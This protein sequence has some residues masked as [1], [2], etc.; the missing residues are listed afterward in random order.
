MSI[1]HNEPKFTDPATMAC[2]GA[3]EHRATWMALLYDCL[4]YT[5]IH[6]NRISGIKGHL[7]HT[8]A[9]MDHAAHTGKPA[10]LLI[11]SLIHI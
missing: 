8:A 7:H 3:V 11:L 2:R 9:C 6:G 10:G 5:S 1:K 4:L